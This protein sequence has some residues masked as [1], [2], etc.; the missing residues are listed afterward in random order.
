MIEPGDKGCERLLTLQLYTSEGP[1]SLISA[2]A[3]TL[4]S[5]PDAKNEF[6]SILNVVSKN[7][8]INEQLDLQGN[9]NARVGTDRDSWPSCLG[10]FG[11]GKV[12]DLAI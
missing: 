1:I 11:G 10:S 4:I 12:N 7:I 3:P 6:Y 2:S 5:T 9:F 8:P